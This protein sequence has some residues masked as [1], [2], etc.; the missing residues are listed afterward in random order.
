MMKGSNI[1]IQEKKA[2]LFNELERFTSTDGE[3]IESYY[4]RFLK[5]MNDFKRNK[6]FPEKIASNLKF[7]NNL[8]PEWSRHVTIVHQT[9]DLH[10]ADYTQLYDFLKYNKKEMI[11]SNSRNRQI[12]QTGMNMGQDRQMQMVGGNDENQFRQ[13]AGQ[14]VGNLN[15]YNIVQNVRNQVVQN[16][17]KNLRVQNVRNHNRLIVVPGIANQYPNRNGNLVAARAEV[18]PRRRDVAYLHNQLLIAQ[19]EE[20]E[21]Q[22]Q[23]KEF[24][25]MAAAA[26]LDEIKEVNA[27]YIMMANLQQASTSE[28]SDDITPSVARKFLNEVKSTIATLQRVVKHRMTFDTHNWSSSA[29]QKLHKIIEDEIFHIVNQVD[30][31]VQNFELQFLKE[32]AKF[33]R[34]FKSLA[35]EAD[36]SLAKHKALELE[37]ERLLRAV[38]ITRGTSM[39]TKLAKQSILGK[40]PYSSRTKLYAVTPIPKSMVFPKVSETHALSK[41]ITLNSVPTPTES[42]VVNNERVI[43]LGIFSINPIKASRNFCSRQDESRRDYNWFENADFV[44]IHRQMR[45]FEY[46][47]Q[48]RKAAVLYEYETFNAIE[49]E[50]LLDT[51]LRYLQVINDLKKCGYKKDNCELNYKFLNYLQPE[52]KQYST[53][54]RQTKNL[55]DINIDALYNIL[56]QNQG[57]MNDALGYKKKAVVITSDPLALVAEK[58]KVNKRKEKVVVSLDSEGSGADDFSELKKITALLAKAFNR[59]KF[60][61]KPTNNNLRTSSTFQSAN[62]KQEFVKSDDKKEDKKADEKKKDISK[63]KCYNCKKEGHFAKE[64][65]KA[66]VKYYNYYKRKM[67]LAKK[68]SDEQ[69]LLAEDQAWMESSSDSDHEINT[70]MVFMAQIKKVLLDSAES[71]SSAEE[72]I[73]EVAYYTSESESES[74]FENSEYYDNSTNYGLF[75]NNND[76]QEIFQDAI[77]SASENFIENHID[78]KKDYDKPEKHIEKANQQSKD[79]ENQNKNLQDKYDILINQVHTFEEKNNEFNE[80]IKVLNEKNA[81]L[82]VKME[83]LQDQL[84]VKH[85]VVDTHTECQAQY[86]KLKEERYE[87]MIRY[88]ALCD[89]DKQHRKKIDEQEISFDKMS[90]QLVEMNNNVLRLQEKILEKETKISESKGCVSNKDVEIEKCLERLNECENKLHKIRQTNQTI[91]MI[92]PSKDTLYNGRKGIGFDNPSYFEKVKD[93]RPSLYDEKV[94]GIEYTLMFL[95]HSDEALEI[96]KFKRAIENKIKFAY[97]YGNLNASYTA[98]L[99][100]ILK[101]EVYV[102]QPPGFV[103]KQYPDHVYALDKALYGLKQVPR[104]WYDVFSQFLIASGF[105]KGSIDTTLFIKKKG[106]HIICS[107]HM[108]GNR[109]LLTNFVEKF[110][111]TVRFGNNDFA[112]IAGYE[113]VVIGSMTIKKV[114]YVEG[115]GDNLFSVGQFCD[116]GLEFTFR[117]STCF[118]RNKYGVYLLTDGVDLLT[119][120]L[121]HLNFATINNLVK[122]NLVQGLP[123]MK[124]KKDHLCSACEQGKIN[125][126]HHK[127]KM[128]FA[129]N[130]PLYLL[131]MDLCG[132]IRV[133][134]INEKGYVL[135]VVDDYSWYTWRVRTDNGTEFKNKTLVKFFDEVGITQ[136]FSAARTPQQNGIVE[137]RNRTLVNAARTMLTFANLPSFLWA[138]AIATDCFIQKRLIIHKRFDK[139]PYELINKRKP[140][141]KFFRVFG[142]RG[143]LLNDYKDVRKLKAKGDI[144]VFVGYSKDSIEPANMDKALRDAEWVSAMQEELDQ[145]TAFLNG[146]LKEEVYVGQPPGFVSKQYSDHVYALGKALY[147]LK[148]A[149]RA[150]YDVLSQ[151]LID[152]GFQKDSGFDLTAYS[153][154]DHAGCHLDQ[155]IESKYVAVSS[156]YAQVLWMRTQLT[157]YGFF[158]DKVPIYCDSKSAIAISCNL[159]EKEPPNSILTWDNLVNKFVNQFFPPSNTTHLKNKISRFTQRFEE[160][161]GEAWEQFKEML[162]A[163]PHHEFSELTQIDTFYNGLNEQDQ[164]SLNAVAGG[165]LLSK[166][167]REG[168]KII[169]NKSKVRYSRGKSNVSRM[170]LNSKESYS[171]TDDR[172]DKLAD[173][174][175]NLVEIANKQV[176]TPA[177]VKGVEKSCVICGGAHDYYDCIATDSNQSSVC[178]ATGSFFQNQALNSGTLSSN[179]IPNPKG[180]VKAVTTRSG[181]AYEGPSIPTN[182]SPEKVVE[183]EIQETTDK[184]QPNCQGSTAHIQPSVVP[185]F[186]NPFF[187]DALLL[188]PKFAST[189]KS[190]LTNKDKLFE[191]AKVPLNENCLAM[192]LKKLPKKLE[193]PDKF[194]IPCDF[195]A[196]DILSII[197]RV[198]ILLWFSN[199]SFSKESKSEFSKEPIVK[200]SSPTLTPFEE[201]DFF[202][203]EIGDFLKDE[204]IPTGIEDSFYDSKGYI[205]YLEKLLNDDPSQLPPMDLKQV[206]ETKAK[207][208]IEEPSELELKELPSHLEYAFLKE[209][210]KLPVII[211]KDL[212]EDEKEALLKVLKSQKQAIAWKITDIKGIDPRFCTHK[213]LMEEDYKPAVQSQRRVNPKTHE[214]IKKEVIKLLDA[215]MIYPI[216]DSP[217]VSPVHCVPKK[218]GMTVV[219]NKNNELILTRLVTGWRV[220]IDYRKLNDATRKEHFS[221]PFMDQML[222]RLA[223]NEFYCFLDGF[224]GYFQIL[225]DPQDQEKTTFTCPY[226]TFSYRRM[227]FGLCNAPGTFQRCMTAIFHDM[228]EKTMEVFMDDFSV[229][230]DSFSSCLSNLDKILK[231][232]E[233]TNLLLNWEKCHFMCKEEIVLGY[234]ISKSRIV[235]NRAKV[236]VIAKLPNPTTVKALELMLPWILKKNTKCLMLLVVSATKLP[237]LNPNE[238]DLWKIRI[239]QYFLMTDYSLW[240]VILSGDSPVPTRIV[241]GVLQPVAPI[242]FE[243]STTDSVST[244]ASISAGGAKL[245]ASPLPNVDSL[246]NAMDLRWQMAMLTMRA[247]RKRYFARKCMF[248]KDSR[249]IGA[250]KPQRRTVL[251]KTSTSNALV[252]QCVESD[253]ESWPPSSLYDRF[254]PSGGYHAVPPPITGTF[255][256]PKPDLVFNTAPTAVETDHHAFNVQLSLTKPDQDL[257]HTT[258]PSAPIIE[259]WVSDSEDESETKAPQ[260]VP[261]FV[262]SFEQVKS[263]RHSGNPQYALKDKGVIDSGCS[264]HMT[265]NM[266][267]LFNF[268]ELNGGYVAFGGNPKGGKISGKGKIKTSKLDFKDVY[269][270]NELK[271]NLFSVS[272]ICDKKN[273][274]LI[275]DT[276]CLVLSL[277]FKLSDESQVLLKVPRENNIYNVNLKNIV[278]SGD[279][280]CLFAKETIDESNLWHRRFCGMKGIKREFDVPR[281]SQQ[282]GI[283]ERKNRTLIEAA[284]TMLADSLLPIPFWVEAVNTACYNNDEDAAF[285]EKEHDFDEKKPESEV[286]LFLSNSAQSRK[287]DDKT[288]KKAKGKNAS[289]LPDDLDMPE[290]EDI[291]YS[292]NEDVVG[293]EADFNNLESSIP[294]SPIPTT[295]IHK[296]YHVSPIIGDLSSTTQTRSMT[297]VVKDQGGLSQMFNDEFHTCM[298]ACFL[299]QEEPKRVYQA[300]KDLSWNEAMQEQLLQ[301]KM[302][303]VWVLVD[304]PNGKNPLEEGIDYEDVFSPVARIEAIRLFLA[305]AS[306]MDF[307]VYQMDVKS[308]FLYGTIEEEVYVC[309]PPGFK[310][311]DHHNKVY[312]V[313]KA[314]YRLHQAHRACATNK[315]LCKSFEKLMKDKF[316]MSSMGEL[317]FFLGLQV[318]QK[319]DGIFICQDKYVA[320]ILRK[321]GLTEGKLASTPIDTEKPLL[322]DSDG[323]DVDVHTYRLMIGSL[324]YLTSSEPD[325]MFACKKKTVVATSSTEAEYVDAA[326]CCAQVL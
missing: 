105:Q 281:T 301:F 321:F 245:L 180:E 322:K 134:R 26:D 190:L 207:S 181:L 212:K 38:D 54:M 318:K 276:E 7:L 148:Q 160:T 85:V 201:S 132:L 287:Q 206:E 116:K 309:Q 82:L 176:I 238:F 129:S 77:R 119:D 280:T 142:C 251:V 98:F 130:K 146:I 78:S 272:Q 289:Q 11:S 292:D 214:V 86:A 165:N 225:I 126:K 31:R 179:T 48:D 273:S 182:S 153:D 29:H 187:A 122:N 34:D 319:K 159:Y 45:G 306:F 84:K 158:Y 99:N 66:K 260:F 298:F 255:M 59:R 270:V 155:K 288:K 115:L 121:S 108:M 297:R 63:V 124:F 101:E 13:Y 87:Y 125:R 55:I 1:E 218:G 243:Q 303:N 308:A 44:V 33:V 293:A 259:D 236:D 163:C 19:K 233:D 194:L 138:E 261:S 17:V 294:V 93:L 302:Q 228:I 157:D 191:L 9:K 70:N 147:G 198:E 311:P 168:L 83:V 313:V 150:W 94:I 57:D 278:P 97:D 230:G 209:T 246:S 117:K 154:A 239:E 208:S 131:H 65:K 114:Y 290:L 252:S 137:R 324:M 144:G 263:P 189:I 53:L 216:F 143:Y 250:A 244:A 40:P 310:D 109:A 92:I 242:T 127:S 5:L 76:N 79:L 314:L 58:T 295:R 32:A 120:D 283:A 296:D 268:E 91:H 215:G 89:N 8:Q 220:C 304:L 183:Q 279:L 317:T 36:E 72:T 266:S 286:I 271:F 21:I 195:S 162:R 300:L 37:I 256:P 113:D 175:S 170:N 112:V 156:C 258:R 185:P 104:A 96:E 12:A 205:L 200:S 307:M 100:G 222:E 202:L 67:L 226:G 199:P 204:S 151:F 326:N 171:K 172:I 232:C 227:P 80:Q 6:H 2:K 247:R 3:S 50:Q 149:P 161:F 64:C 166:T 43:A 35:K 103:S 265:G 248:P 16:V 316:Q 167:T 74:E 231:G 22:L 320:E 224:S 41:P 69:V 257:S 275:T 213:I 107:K 325:I 277:D 15:G 274:V 223:R 291:T 267:Y 102:G 20:A 240:E 241:E 177:T 173:Q 10:T 30:A 140:N 88:S 282:N 133:Q 61:S 95:I 285:D 118:V 25:F 123:K 197:S 52:W 47:E 264:R 73:N 51:Y 186:R 145:F 46:G 75:M 221:L 23:A 235:V 284:R 178:A 323:E 128:A 71:S 111:G 62:K 139:T 164:D 106:K 219:A 188:M 28:F 184:E 18:R 315:D 169:E 305:Y 110:L 90:R 24:D 217:W 203:E 68:D 211:E 42:T 49:E 193:D 4:H 39:N 141:I 312:K 136:Q 237:I 210:N 234:K 299:S 229:F 174:I 56:K 269:F 262:Q 192:L 135:F 27:N 254:Q 14:N 60:Y 249:R 253:C 152:S 196:M 81:D